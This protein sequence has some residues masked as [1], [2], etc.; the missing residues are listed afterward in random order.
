MV[1]DAATAVAGNVTSV[2]ATVPV[3]PALPAVGNV[4]MYVYIYMY[5]CIYVERYPYI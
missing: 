3:P 4:Y 2:A 5:V 1:V